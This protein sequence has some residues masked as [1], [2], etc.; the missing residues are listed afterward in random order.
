M[1]KNNKLTILVGWKRNLFWAFVA[2]FVL[3]S[4]F[5]IGGTVIL[6]LNQE[7]V[8][9][10]ITREINRQQ[11]LVINYQKVSVN[12]IQNFPRFSYTFQN[13]Q[14]IQNDAT[15]PVLFCKELSVTIQPFKLLAGKLIAESISAK[16]L[17]LKTDIVCLENI[18]SGG[19]GESTTVLNIS[20]VSIRDYD[21]AIQDSS[22]KGF[23]NLSG[24]RV[25][26]TFFKE[27]KKLS[28]FSSVD[29]NRLS[30]KDFIKCEF[31]IS[32]TIEIY[33]DSKI[34]NIHNIKAKLNS[35]ELSGIGNYEEDSGKAKFRFKSN[36]FR[37]NSLS[38]IPSLKFS[39]NYGGRGS[40]EG[41]IS[42]SGHFQNIDTLT[43]KYHIEKVLINDSVKI[44]IGEL[45]GYS[46]LTNNLTFHYSFIPKANISFNGLSSTLSAHLKGVKKMVIQST[47][48]INGDYEISSLE[49]TIN[50][51]GKFDL[52][53][54]YNSGA[55]QKFVLRK[56]NSDINFN[57]KEKLFSSKLQL[58]GKAKL[59]NNLSITGSLGID[60]TNMSFNLY[61][62]KLIESLQSNIINPSVELWGPYINYNDISTLIKSGQDQKNSTPQFKS[63][64]LKINFK[65]AIYD[66]LVLEN[67]KANGLYKNDTINLNYFSADCFGGNV[68]GKFFTIGNR[69]N[70]NMWLYN[71]D[72]QKLF[73]RYDNWGQ[74]YITSQN[75]SGRFKGLVDLSFDT[76]NKGNIN[77]NSL[78][79]KS[80]IQIFNGKLSGM[81][82]IK[83]LSSWLNLDQVKVI[84]FDTLKNKIL[85][86]N[87]KIIIPSMDV[88]S[89]VV[90]MNIA[91]SHTFSNSYQY[92]VRM[93]F[94][95][96]LKRKFVRSDKK[97]SDLS[98]DGTINLYFKISGK[99]EDYIVEW[100]NRKN[101][102]KNIGN[103]SIAEPDSAL[104]FSSPKSKAKSDSIKSIP[105]KEVRIDWDEMVDTLNNE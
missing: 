81:D 78:T 101:F 104:L 61:Q 24:K 91:G 3:T 90:L 84:E 93:N 94:G 53:S 44:S 74:N 85:I 28:L 15:E 62:D 4:S 55:S 29:A 51:N 47:G 102:E 59:D 67:L 68:S 77:S 52:V 57:S 64:T 20:K 13:L 58:S 87:K 31:P 17:K 72:I 70:A 10:Y 40:L 86:E 48:T 49:H 56:I 12:T 63:V 66:R 89:N 41:Y 88:K 99:D 5:F 1:F 100:L 32:L 7:R 26:V 23:L 30:I 27:S 37:I 95:N 25:N 35:I 73:E 69:Y 2:L 33:K 71:I 103:I 65:K 16:G 21:I 14:V 11:S 105:K 6:M 38:F 50:V 43:A 46:I 39:K 8:I 76:D 98:T 45:A 54:V 36:T 97:I 83:S 60:S 92:H 42:T 96:V 34:F 79:L 82:R 18:Q 80:D 75:I 9:D 19:E 22:G